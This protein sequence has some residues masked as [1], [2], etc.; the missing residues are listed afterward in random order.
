MEKISEMLVAVRVAWEAWREAL[1]VAKK[2]E[3][4]LK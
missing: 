1:E 4:K 2:H 3:G